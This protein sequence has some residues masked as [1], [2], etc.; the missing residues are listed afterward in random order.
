MA[1]GRRAALLNGDPTCDWLRI[2]VTLLSVAAKGMGS[3]G[4]DAL[5]RRALL[6]FILLGDD[7]MGDK[8]LGI[9]VVA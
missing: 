5:L 7:F 6:L 3:F 1:P 2:E 8:L 4:G 9:S